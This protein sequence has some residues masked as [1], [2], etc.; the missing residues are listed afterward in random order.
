MRILALTELE[1][2]TGFAATVLLALHHA[3][4]T[5]E[6]A[7]FFQGRSVLSVDADQ[8]A[9]HGQANG[10]GLTFETPAAH[11]HLQVVVAHF[12]HHRKRLLHNGLQNLGRE[13]GIQGFLVDGDRAVARLHVE[14]G[15]GGL[16]P[17]DRVGYVHI[18]LI[19][20]F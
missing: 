9:G 13:V 11:V 15:Y 20:R 8:R 7:F 19:L 12:F 1:G 14:A 6:E 3:G 18:I 10:F 17:S 5:R 16:A 4:I 2:P